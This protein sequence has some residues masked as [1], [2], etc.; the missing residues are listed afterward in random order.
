MDNKG[1]ISAEYLLLVLVFLI[2]LGSITIPLMGRSINASSDVSA[3]SDARVAVQS[4]ANA[5]NIV[6][7]NGMGARRTLNVYVPQNTILNFTN[8][9]VAMRIVSSQG[10]LTID[11]RTDYNLANTTVNVNKGWRNVRIEWTVGSNYI[12]ITVT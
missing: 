10:N 4:I 12:T 5:A 9:T 2:I 1:Q 8:R 3:A 6:Y 7:A 11:Q